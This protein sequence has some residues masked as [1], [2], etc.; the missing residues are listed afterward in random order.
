MSLEFGFSFLFELKGKEEGKRKGEKV[1]KEATKK[2]RG[3]AI[4]LFFFFERFFST[5]GFGFACLLASSFIL[6]AVCLV[7]LRE[8]ERER[9]K[10][11]EEK[12]KKKKGEEEKKTGK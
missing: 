10:K 8:K 11:K 1:R 3:N 12:K 2:E 9:K 6:H 7:F 4:V 5:L